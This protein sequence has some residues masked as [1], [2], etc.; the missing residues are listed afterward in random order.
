MSSISTI[1]TLITTPN[2]IDE[3]SIYSKSKPSTLIVIDF[4]FDLFFLKC[5]FTNLITAVLKLDASICVLIGL[6][7]L[8]NI[9]YK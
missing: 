1:T 5:F 9:K 4:S 2:T 7:I 6:L 3:L 8:N